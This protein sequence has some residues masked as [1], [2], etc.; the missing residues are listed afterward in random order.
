MGEHLT[1]PDLGP[2][3]HKTQTTLVAGKLATTLAL[4]A[5]ATLPKTCYLHPPHLLLSHPLSEDTKY[6]ATLR[7]RRNHQ[8]IIGVALYTPQP[9]RTVPMSHHAIPHT[10][11]LEGLGHT[12]CIT[13]QCLHHLLPLNMTSP[14]CQT[15]IGSVTETQ[16]GA[17]GQAIL[18][19]EGHLTTTSRTQTLPQN[20]I[21]ITPTTILIA[22]MTG[23]TGETAWA[24]GQVNTVTRDTATTTIL[25]TTTAAAAVEGAATTGIETETETVTIQTVLTP[26]TIPTP[27]ALP[28]IVCLLP[29][30]LIPHTPPPKSLPQPLL[31]DRMFPA[32]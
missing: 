30:R 26:D 17:M 12:W 32:E 6:L 1:A 7:M 3:S 27:T 5:A 21:P 14:Q 29:P 10:P 20:I 24:L 22:G 23:G 16:G 9:H 2:L 19:P 11:V 8:C 15:G 31:R 25:I 28:L 13:P 18:A 4:W